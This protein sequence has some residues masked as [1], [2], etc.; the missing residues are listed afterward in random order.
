MAK[1]QKASD[2][3][4]QHPPFLGTTS[5][6][7]KAFPHIKSVKMVIEEQDGGHRGRVDG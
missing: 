2:V 6:F 5:S 4:A 1:H 7:A 3:A